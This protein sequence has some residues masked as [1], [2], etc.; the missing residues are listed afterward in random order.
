MMKYLSLVHIMFV[1]L[2]VVVEL[3]LGCN[4]SNTN[5]YVIIVPAILKISFRVRKKNCKPD[6][7][8]ELLTTSL[9]SRFDSVF[10]ESAEI[11]RKIQIGR[12]DSSL[13]RAANNDTARVRAI[14]KA[15][16]YQ[17]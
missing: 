1:V 5:S 3:L 11:D 13:T 10:H 12:V 14:E 6:S 8:I 16:E 9:N 4:C 15:S 2:E 7:E 17:K